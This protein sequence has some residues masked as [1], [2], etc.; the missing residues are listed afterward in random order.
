LTTEGRR[1]L[2][3]D[4]PQSFEPDV[5]EFWGVLKEVRDVDEANRFGGEGA[6]RRVVY[7]DHT[8]IEVISSRIP[9]PFPTFSPRINYSSANNQPWSVFTESFRVAAPSG[10]RDLYALEG[11]RVHWKYGQATLRQNLGSQESPKWEDNT[12]A[13]AWQIVEVEGWGTAS[14]VQSIDFEQVIL[15]MAEGKTGNEFMQ[16]YYSD[17]SIR[18]HSGYTEATEKLA[19]GTLLKELVEAGKLTVDGEGKHSKV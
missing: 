13:K 14:A 9:F 17:N 6:K 2:S 8:D 7:F 12:D 16:A 3:A 4:P 18:G 11:K 15:D 1:P 10:E 19:R 5:T